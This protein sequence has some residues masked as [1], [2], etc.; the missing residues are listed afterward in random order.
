MRATLKGTV[1]KGKIVLQY[2]SLDELNRLHELLE[3]V[4]A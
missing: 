3:Q 2:N 1:K 4:D